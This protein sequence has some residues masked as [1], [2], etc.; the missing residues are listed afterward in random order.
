MEDKIMKKEPIVNLCI[1]TFNRLEYTKKCI[2]SILETTTDNIPFMITVVD[3]GSSDETQEYLKKIH[4]EGKIN[5]LILLGENIGIAKA[6]NIGWKM[7]EDI[8]FE[9]K[10]D[11]D[12]VFN[13][14]GWLDA[15]VNTFEKSTKIGALGYQCT[16]DRAEYPIIKENDTEYRVKNGNIGGACFFVPKHVKDQLGFWNESIQKFYGEEDSDYGWRITCAGYKNAYMVD[17]S[18]ITHLPDG[19]GDYREFKDK[20]REN[21]LKGNFWPTLNGYKNGTIPLK[22][23]TNIL[24]EIDLKSVLYK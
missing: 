5:T 10:I 6:Q 2:A 9:A 22:I 12:I 15:I 17:T 8:P 13:K 7:F 3:N 11:N 4:N 18:V 24:G 21:N 1:T 23:E 16:D 14:K 20:E 19:Q